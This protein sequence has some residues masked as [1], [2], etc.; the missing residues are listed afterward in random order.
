MIGKEKRLYPEIFVPSPGHMGEQGLLFLSF[1][2]L[3]LYSKGRVPQFPPVRR[4]HGPQSH[5]K[6]GKGDEKKNLIPY[7]ELNCTH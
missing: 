2:S 3:L 6:W 5:S 1:I 4:L 7:W